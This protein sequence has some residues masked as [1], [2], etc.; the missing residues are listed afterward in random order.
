MTQSSMHTLVLNVI[1]QVTTERLQKAVDGSGA[2]FTPS[3]WRHSL[4][5]NTGLC[6]EWRRQRV[7]RGA[8]PRTRSVPK[9][10]VPQGSASMRSYA[11]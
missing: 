5:R 7:R 4:S 1:Q 2:V 6:G 9:D 10:A 11:V 8:Q 3:L